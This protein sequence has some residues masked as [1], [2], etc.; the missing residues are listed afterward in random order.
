MK[1]LNIYRGYGD[2]ESTF[3]LHVGRGRFR[4]CSLHSDREGRLYVL[5]MAATLKAHYTVKDWEEKDRL[6]S[7]KPVHNGDYV[8]VPRTEFVN[9]YNE[10]VRH[11][12]GIFEVKVNGDYADAA[13]LVE[14]QS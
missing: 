5:Q 7:E 2:Q 4:V 6:M 3:Y 8:R 9:H 14:V 13:H 12:G 10:T 11:P 1:T